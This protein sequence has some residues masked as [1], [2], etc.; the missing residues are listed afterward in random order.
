LAKTIGFEAKQHADVRH[1]QYPAQVLSRSLS[2][3]SIL[4]VVCGSIGFQSGDQI[5]SFV[6]HRT[7][8]RQ[9]ADTR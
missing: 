1:T 2:R 5:I 7:V 3:V 8:R 6:L 9:L 4:A